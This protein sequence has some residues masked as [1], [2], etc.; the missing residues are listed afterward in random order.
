MMKLLKKLLVFAL[1]AIFSVSL[2]SCDNQW[3]SSQAS[4]TSTQSSSA[5][6]ST[7]QQSSSV[8]KSS[9]TKSSSQQSSSSSQQSSSSQPEPQAPTKKAL[10]EYFDK[11]DLNKGYSFSMDKITTSQA[12]SEVPM[13][14]P[15]SADLAFQVDENGAL[16]TNLSVNISDTNLSL[17]LDASNFAFIYN[18]TSVHFTMDKEQFSLPGVPELDTSS[19][20]AYLDQYILSGENGSSLE[21]SLV[22]EIIDILKLQSNGM[23]DDLKVD[24]SLVDENMQIKLSVAM[25]SESGEDSNFNVYFTIEKKAYVAKE[26]PACDRVYDLTKII[27]NGVSFVDALALLENNDF[28]NGQHYHILL[29]LQNNLNGIN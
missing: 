28:S 10:A 22:P 6:S 18:D 4:T 12:F 7:Q 2:F 29:L 13:P 8:A 27:K 24:I 26:I 20:S 19:M 5:Q 14:I 16:N 21:F 15:A 11:E 25:P 17:Y 23:I 9:T 3:S 1:V